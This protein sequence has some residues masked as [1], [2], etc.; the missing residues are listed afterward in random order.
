MS[1]LRAKALRLLIATL[2]LAAV[3][4]VA[5]ALSRAQNT[6][7]DTIDDGLEFRNDVLYGMPTDD[8]TAYE[9]TLLATAPAA[10]QQA[11]VPVLAFTLLAPLNYNSNAEF[12]RSG[13]TETVEGSPEVRMGSATQLGTLPI[14][15]S[16]SVALE[17]DRFVSSKIAG[18]DKIRPRLQAQYVDAD[19]DQA[20]S[21]FFGFS[22]RWDYTPTF[23]DNFATRYDLNLGVYKA[24]RFDEAFGR[25]PASGNSSAATA[26]SL[27]YTIIGQRRFR[28]PAPASS[29]LLVIPSASYRFSEEWSCAFAIELTQRWI[30]G[31][32]GVSQNNFTFY[33]LAAVELDIPDRWLGGPEVARWFGRPALDFFGG[34]ERNWSNVT[35]A[36]FVQWTAG[37][38]IKGAWRL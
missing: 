1:D 26:L 22:P 30:D 19:D 4:L 7:Q 12:A 32:Q 20:F 5:P 34:V 33:P 25:V 24:F 29:A 3:S 16:G 13:G 8:A 37:F 6:N 23:A 15:V 28:E 11:R 38:A 36:N 9:P 35:S 10:E 17:W 18:F 31:Y 27:G 14:R 2:G 21:P